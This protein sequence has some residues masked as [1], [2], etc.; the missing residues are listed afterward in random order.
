[1][2]YLSIAQFL[3]WSGIALWYLLHRNLQIGMLALLLVH[4]SASDM[5]RYAKEKWGHDDA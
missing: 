3:L 2:L 1:M 5:E 4:V